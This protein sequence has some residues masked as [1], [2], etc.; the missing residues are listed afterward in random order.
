MP[1]TQENVETLFSQALELPE[2]DMENFCRK[3]THEEAIALYRHAG[4]HE[5]D[6]MLS[7]K[8]WWI[9]LNTKARRDNH[10]N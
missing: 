1:V 9:M 7:R 4:K 2:S 10:I 3:L 6:P 5:D 8:V